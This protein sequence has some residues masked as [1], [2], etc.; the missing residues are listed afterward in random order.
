MLPMANFKFSVGII[1]HT[2][3]EFTRPLW[4]LT[5]SWYQQFCQQTIRSRAGSRKQKF[6]ELWLLTNVFL[7]Q[8]LSK[9]DVCQKP[10]LFVITGVRYNR[11][12]VLA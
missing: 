2:E 3:T 5:L 9:P 7:S 6:E 1:F 11:V 4:Y 8:T 10:D 12:H